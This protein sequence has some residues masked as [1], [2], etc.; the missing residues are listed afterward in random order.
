MPQQCKHYQYLLL[1]VVFADASILAHCTLTL[2]VHFALSFG[3][4]LLDQL[5]ELVW[6]YSRLLFIS[7]QSV[8]NFAHWVM[9]FRYG[10]CLTGRSFVDF[11]QCFFPNWLEKLQLT[12]ARA[13]L[14]FLS[15]ER[16]KQLTIC[17][18]IWT[19]Q[20]HKAQSRIYGAV[21]WHARAKLFL[22]AGVSW[23]KTL[24]YVLSSSA[25]PTWFACE[26]PTVVNFPC[27]THQST[28]SLSSL[29]CSFLFLCSASFNCLSQH[30]WRIIHAKPICRLTQIYP[31]GKR[32]FPIGFLR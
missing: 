11:S 17:A 27:W 4:S 16:G 1:K 3:L 31:N 24:G 12:C 7:R 14:L 2:V 21:R 28:V 32:H 6:H 26:L 22:F 25:E 9:Q 20:V 29:L 19:R 23:A 15:W 5:S 18:H 30:F 8:S 10:R 13:L